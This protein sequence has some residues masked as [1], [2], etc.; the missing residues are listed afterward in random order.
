[1][2]HGESDRAAA[3]RLL[4]EI[5]DLTEKLTEHGEA[6]ASLQP[7]VVVVLR[8]IGRGR[9]LDEKIVAAGKLDKTLVF[10]VLK[11]PPALLSA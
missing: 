2:F 7:E 10:Q 9:R 3:K 1:M 8:Q 6:V 11:R 4:R 5:A